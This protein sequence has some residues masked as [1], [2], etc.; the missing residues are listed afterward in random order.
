MCIL[1]QQVDYDPEGIQGCGTKHPCCHFF[2]IFIFSCC[3]LMLGYSEASFPPA[4]LLE[5]PAPAL[6]FSSSSMRGTAVTATVNPSLLELLG[7]SECKGIASHAS[8][9]APSWSTAPF[10]GA[11]G[12][13]LLRRNPCWEGELWWNTGI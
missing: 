1:Q 6:C 10:H 9:C 11:A 8:N 12:V 3:I 5:A 13:Q 2:L 4:L 7:G